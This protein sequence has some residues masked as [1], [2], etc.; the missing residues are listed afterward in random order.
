M[1]SWH[2]GNTDLK[3]KGFYEVQITGRQM[4]VGVGGGGDEALV[5]LVLGPRYISL[6]GNFAD[7]GGWTGRDG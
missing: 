3:W 2:W 5:G 4:G 7:S 1:R 6:H